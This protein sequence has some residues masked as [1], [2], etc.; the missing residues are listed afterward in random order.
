MTV[1][2][3]LLCFLAGVAKAAADTL[4]FWYDHSIF[5]K[6]PRSWWDPIVSWENK[7]KPTN[8]FVR[9][10]TRTIFVTFTDAWHMFEMF[11]TA[12]LIV[13]LAIAIEGGF[14]L[15]TDWTNF[16]VL[17][18]TI[19]AVVLYAARMSGFTFGVALFKSVS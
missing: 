7:N 19:L 2:L 15:Y 3:V 18:I 8:Y 9:M 10:L 5:K 6:F 13:A 1:L 4:T 16:E 12:F 17:N 14:D 11:Q